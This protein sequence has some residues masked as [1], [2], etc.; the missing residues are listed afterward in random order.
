[1]TEKKELIR[2]KWTYISL[3]FISTLFLLANIFL[4]YFNIY[5]QYRGCVDPDFNLT[6]T[7]RITLLAFATYVIAL[8]AII[9]SLRDVIIELKRYEDA[10][11]VID[12]S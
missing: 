10:G 6:E 7:V 12:N 1:M 9:I 2:K 5:F 4:L 11:K 3:I 8:A